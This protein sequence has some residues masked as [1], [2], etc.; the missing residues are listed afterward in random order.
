MYTKVPSNQQGKTYNVWHPIKN[1]Q[2]G[3]ETGK[4]IMRKKINQK[5]K[6]MK[7][8][9]KIIDNNIKTSVITILWI[10]RKVE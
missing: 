5:N 1:C 9:L 7:Q 2:A 6:L 8:M 4:N 10:F 3:K